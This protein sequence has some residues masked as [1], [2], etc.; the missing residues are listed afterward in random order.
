MP[1]T[2]NPETAVVPYV[3]EKQAEAEETALVVAPKA[4]V[5]YAVQLSSRPPA[6]MTQTVERWVQF[7]DEWVWDGQSKRYFRFITYNDG[8]MTTEWGPFTASA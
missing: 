6:N 1:R 8:Y 5:A 2:W 4:E 7:V 3:E